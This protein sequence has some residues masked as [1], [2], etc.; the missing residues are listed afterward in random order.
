MSFVYH[1]MAGAC[2][3][4]MEHMGLYPVDTL[5]VSIADL[6]FYLMWFIFVRLTFKHQEAILVFRGQLKFYT[7]MKVHY[8][9]GKGLML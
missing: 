9:F 4:I 8:V 1:C 3:G 5:K 2:A 7:K 6:H